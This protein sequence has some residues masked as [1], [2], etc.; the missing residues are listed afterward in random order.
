MFRR[1]SLSL[2][3][4]VALASPALSASFAD[5]GEVIAASG[6]VEAVSP[7]Q[8]RPLSVGDSVFEGEEIVTEQD[9]KVHIR[10]D[11]GTSLRLGANSRLQLERFMMA[12]KDAEGVLSLGRGTLRTISGKI[13]KV[14]GGSLTLD[15]PT[16][17]LAVRGTDFYTVQGEDG[18]KVALIDDGE[19]EVSPK[20]GPASNSVTVTDPQTGVEVTANG[21]SSAVT[22]LTEVD[23]ATLASRVSVPAP[24]PRYLV[25]LALLGAYLGTLL[26]FRWVR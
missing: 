2:V 8:R 24:T 7:V 5:I 26:I 20:M 15:T 4:C 16:A 3:A 17:A 1:F 10:L 19:V 22:A 25:L 18:V 11:D 9:E 6:D 21:V 23:L 13:N 12:E 14:S